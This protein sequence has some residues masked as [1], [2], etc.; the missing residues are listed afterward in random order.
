MQDKRQ[1]I[2]TKKRL[3]GELRREIICKSRDFYDGANGK[4]KEHFNGTLQQHWR[5]DMFL[6]NM[7]VIMITTRVV[8]TVQSRFEVNEACVTIKNQ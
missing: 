2:D 5:L 1:V 4:S 3:M 8:C 6:T 7:K